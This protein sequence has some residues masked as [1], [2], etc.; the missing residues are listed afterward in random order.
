MFTIIHMMYLNHH[1]DYNVEK[2]HR[3]TKEGFEWILIQLQNIN[4]LR[5]DMVVVNFEDDTIIE[6]I[7]DGVKL[8]NLCYDISEWPCLPKEFKVIQTG[9]PINYWLKCYNDNLEYKEDD[10]EKWFNYDAIVWFDHSLVK[11]QCLANVKLEE[12]VIDTTFI[13]N[14]VKYTIY[15]DSMET[16]NENSECDDSDLH[17]FKELLLNDNDIVFVS[18]SL[19]FDIDDNFTLFIPRE[20]NNM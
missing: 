10:A 9:L 16:G 15:L 14:D 8:I 11:D 12:G 1:L 19:N 7:F 3:I 4:L 13:F 18:S 5:G 17:K 20:F 2:L 6:L